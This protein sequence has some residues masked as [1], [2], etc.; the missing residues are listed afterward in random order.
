MLRLIAGV[1]II[2]K[3][4]SRLMNTANDLDHDQDTPFNRIMRKCPGLILMGWATLVI[5]FVLQFA[6][7]AVPH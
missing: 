5:V 1:S 4:M 2:G 6:K 7:L 3:S